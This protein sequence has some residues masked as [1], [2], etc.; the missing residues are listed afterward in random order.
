M[1]THSLEAAA[2]CDRVIRMQDG[3]IVG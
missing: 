3:R 2:I 1:A